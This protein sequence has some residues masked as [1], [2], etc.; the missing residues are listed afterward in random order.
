MTTC[1]NK[2]RRYQSLLLAVT[3]SISTLLVI[4]VTRT[5]S[6]YDQ[7]HPR[8]YHA[9]SIGL[10]D[11]LRR[12][13]LAS[14]LSSSSPPSPV[15]TALVSVSA[16]SLQE[17]SSSTIVTTICTVDVC[18]ELHERYLCLDKEGFV[19]SWPMAVKILLLIILMMFSALF[20]GL[21]LGLMTLDVTGLEI[22]MAGDDLEAAKYAKKIYPVRKDSILLLCTLLLGNAAVNSLFSAEIFDGLVGYLLST[23]LIVVFGEIIPQAYA[24]KV[25]LKKN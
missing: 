17:P 16:R 23:G 3:T 9:G 24:R 6:E 14:A 19:S 22:V 10:S 12:G 18:K 8:H 13:S 15:T 1:N 4:V 21:T 5:A 7:I 20:S 11:M 2:N 25:K